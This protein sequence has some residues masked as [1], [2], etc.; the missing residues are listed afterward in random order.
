MGLG[1][2][3]FTPESPRPTLECGERARPRPAEQQETPQVAGV[4]AAVPR[5]SRTPS[6]LQRASSIMLHLYYAHPF[7]LLSSHPPSL[8][9]GFG[10]AGTPLRLS[11]IRRENEREGGV[12]R[13]GPG[14]PC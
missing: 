9:R 5:G 7:P 2:R 14:L 8:L 1:A 10:G 13:S 6:H 4:Q 12:V 11:Y 3:L